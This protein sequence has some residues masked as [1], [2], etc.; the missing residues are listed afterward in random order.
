MA[1]L[2][3]EDVLR[4]PLITEKN[5]VIM[6]RGQ[7]T[8]EVHPDANKI[9]IRAAVEELFNVKVT[10]VNTLNRKPKVKSRGIRRGRGRIEGT[11]GGFKKAYVSLAPGQSLD[12]FQL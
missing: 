7:Y 9:Q 12:P 6:E 5:T 11:S 2:R 4:R 3:L 8:F 10:A 1:E